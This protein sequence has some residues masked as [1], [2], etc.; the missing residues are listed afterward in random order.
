MI[1]VTPEKQLFVIIYAN[2]CI[3]NLEYDHYSW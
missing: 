3:H 2:I 1:E